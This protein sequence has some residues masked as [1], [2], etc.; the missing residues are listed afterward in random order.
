M[1]KSK[2]LV[3]S[4]AALAVSAAAVSPAITADA[5]AVNPVVLKAKSFRGG[6]VE[7]PTMYGNSRIVWDRSTIDWNQINKFQTVYGVVGSQERPIQMQINLLNYPIFAEKAEPQVIKLGEKP[8]LPERLNIKFVDKFYPNAIKWEE[9]PVADKEGT[10][11]VKGTYTKDGRTVVTSALYTVEGVED[12]EAPELKYEGPG[13]YD[14]ENGAKFELPTVKAMDNV[15]EEI[16]VTHVIKDASGKELDAIDTKVAGKYTITFMAEDK[17]GNKAKPVEIQV[18]VAEALPKVESVTPIDANKLKVDFNKAVDSTKAKVSLKKGAVVYNATVAFS[19][20]SKSATITTP[21]DLAEGEYTVQ[22]EGLTETALTQNVTIVKEVENAIEITSALVQAL[23]D[24]T[25]SFKVLN[26][27]GAD[28]EVD[29]SDVIVT[30]YNV[31]KGKTVSVTGDADESKIKF[32]NLTDDNDSQTSED[33]VVGDKVRVTISYKGI[34]AQ[35]EIEIIKPAATASVQL[36]QVQPLKDT[37]RITEGDSGL[38]LPYTLADQY[39]NSIKFSAASSNNDDNTATFDGV[40]FTSSD[41]NVIDPDSFAVDSEGKLTFTAVGDGKA[42]ITAIINATGQTASVEVTVNKSA[43]LNKLSISGATKLVAAGETVELDF[44]AE[45][46]YGTTLKADSSLLSQAVWTSSDTDVVANDDI[47][48]A[49]GKIKVVTNEDGKTTLTAKKLDGTVLGTVTLEVEAA[50]K[51]SSITGVTGVATVLTKDATDTIKTENVV[52]KDQYNRI[53]ELKGDEAVKVYVKD[54]SETSLDIV[55]TAGESTGLDLLNA[56]TVNATNSSFVTLTGLATTGSETLV[57]QLHDGTNA[58]AGGKFELVINTKAVADV[59]T[60]ELATIPTLYASEDDS[61]E[62]A[63]K[64]TAKDSTGNVVAIPS[65][66]I[67]SITS[68]NNSIVKVNSGKLEGVSKGTATVT[69]VIQG[70]EGLVTL[71]QTVTVSDD[72]LV[73]QKIESNDADNNVSLTAAELKGLDL[74]SDESLLY[75]TVTDQFD[76]TSLVPSDFIVTN[77]VDASG[78]DL[79]DADFTFEDSED[80]D[81]YVDTITVSENVVAGDSFKLTAVAPNGKTVAVTITIAAE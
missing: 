77:I 66:S 42:R 19:A 51:P 46:Q 67:R 49:K 74:T 10:F 43:E 73:A 55:D 25:I 54:G 2:K 9:A 65:T 1:A 14:I 69:V 28:M 75:F 70:A 71:T 39:G 47:D 44:V 12:K 81:T 63:V 16:E 11:F 58:V 52:I 40:L 21:I 15:D 13:V 24:S 31:T 17:A 20:D 45:D 5:A 35:K 68:S 36:S 34:T 6:V 7:L 29:G 50:A 62:K 57:L 33:A 32:A 27:Y 22:V 18:M 23:D 30:A 78:N 79:I 41:V 80:A 8:V 61:Y 37:V 72:V 60:Y 64:V 38:V 26:Q 76:G 48:F 4:L 53:Y 56:T 3:T 59:K